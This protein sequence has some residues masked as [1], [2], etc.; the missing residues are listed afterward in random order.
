MK[1]FFITFLLL[2]NLLIFPEDKA[3]K[4]AIVIEENSGKHITHD[5]SG[6]WEFYWNKLI[7]PADF[8]KDSKLRPDAYLDL[9]SSWT[10][11]KPD[12]KKVD[13]LGYAT[14]RLKIHHPFSGKEAAVKLRQINY[15]YILYADSKE[16]ARAGKI[17]NKRQ[18]FKAEIKPQTVYFIPQNEETVFVMNISNFY[19]GLGGPIERITLGL[20]QNIEKE[21][22]FFVASDIFL[23][24]SRFFLLLILLAVIIFLKSR[25]AIFFFFYNLAMLTR[26]AGSRE[27][28]YFSL[29]SG[30]DFDFFYRALAVS[31]YIQSFFLMLTIY[32]LLKEKATTKIRHNVFDY[33]FKKGLDEII[34]FISS[35]LNISFIVFFFTAGNELFLDYHMYY[36]LLMFFNIIYPLKI[37]IENKRKHGETTVFLFIYLFI[38]FFTF[39]IAAEQLHFIKENYIKPFF[40]LNNSWLSMVKIPMQYLSYIYGL[41]VGFYIIYR[42]FKKSFSHKSMEETN[43]ESLI[44]EY[45]ITRREW[46]IILFAVK[47]FSYETIAEKAFIAKSTVKTHLNRIY[48][49]LK[50]KNKTELANKLAKYNIK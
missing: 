31:S 14:I 50:V 12:D 40:F 6:E 28:L 43:P 26:L 41:I 44:E 17:S 38:I 35:I 19:G 3:F 15:S 18:G 30:M 32:T 4:G 46:E 11:L 9:P 33:I 37:I 29:F 25:A 5:L 39:F 20:R 45:G 34:I 42:I 13:N 36:I 1:T 27:Q 10:S 22:N 16:I 2:F 23:L 49:K 21:S 24:G 48:Q 8:D 47:G 7:S